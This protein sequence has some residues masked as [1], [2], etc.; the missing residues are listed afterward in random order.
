VAGPAAA[1]AA[2]VCRLLAGRGVAST[3]AYWNGRDESPRAV[4]NASITVL[5]ALAGS[6]VDCYLSLKAP[7]LGY[8]AELA[9]EVAERARDAGRRVLFDSLGPE[10]ADRT[11]ELLE[12]LDVA[13]L[14]VA[15]P[16]RWRR[17]VWDAE[18]AIEHGW[19]VRVVKGQWAD[20]VHDQKSWLG[21]LALV[22]A[23]AGRR[24]SPWPRTT[25]RSLPRPFDA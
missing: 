17:S 4:A 13:E 8:S 2:R 14:G 22:D 20:S 24:T 10:H 5:D 23:L 16:A 15:L 18:R 1:D 6:N 9:A 11:L 25:G 21:L 7:A 3:A 12:G 19:R